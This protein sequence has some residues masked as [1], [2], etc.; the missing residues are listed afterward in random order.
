MFKREEITIIES[1][2]M[3]DKAQRG[4]LPYLFRL[5]SPTLPNGS[6]AVYAWE[7]D[8]P[9][10]DKGRKEFGYLCIENLLREAP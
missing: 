6:L 4:E 3:E 1:G 2:F 10:P 5:Q 9:I 7:Q 8:H